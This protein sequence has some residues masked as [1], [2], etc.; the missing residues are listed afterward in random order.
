MPA[1]GP[2]AN[3]PASPADRVLILD[4]LAVQQ[5]SID[6]ATRLLATAKLKLREADDELTAAEARIE[7]AEA[8]FD[9]AMSEY[10]REKRA[11]HKVDAG[12]FAAQALLDEAVDEAS[13]IRAPFHPIRRTPPEVLGLIFELCVSPSPYWRGKQPFMLSHMRI[14]YPPR[15]RLGR[16][17][18]LADPTGSI[19]PPEYLIRGP[20][21][22]WANPVGV[23]TV[24]TGGSRWG[25]DV[26][27]GSP[28]IFRR[29]ARYETVL[30]EALDCEKLPKQHAVLANEVIGDS[31]AVLDR[32]LRD[33]G[34]EG[35]R[36]KP[37]ATGSPPDLEIKWKT[38]IRGSLPDSRGLRGLLGRPISYP[39]VVGRE[40]SPRDFMARWR[41]ITQAIQIW[42]I[43][44]Q[45]M[46][47]SRAGVESK[48][49][50]VPE[51]AFRRFSL[52]QECRQVEDS[53]LVRIRR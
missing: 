48:T 45:D 39:G 29:C 18:C 2:G 25:L 43:L 41:R 32:Y 15:R 51:L 1:H 24:K 9:A 37:L 38:E 31:Q 35:C 34:S 11:H 14:L 3:L 36:S 28:R 5:R 20:I 7:A 8:V 42:D 13:I 17:Q 47:G 53:G 4:R 46:T 26:G 12:V 19:R 33:F 16:R 52:G 6:A 50:R 49:R 40:Q 30:R 21:S 10:R 44:Q 23:I 27:S 22:T